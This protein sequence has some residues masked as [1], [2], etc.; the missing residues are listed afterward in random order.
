LEAGKIINEASEAGKL[1]LTRFERDSL[2]SALKVLEEL[3]M[4]ADQFTDECLRIYTRKVAE[5]DPKSYE[6]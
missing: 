6:L 1:Y 3:P 2:D 5:F 4:D